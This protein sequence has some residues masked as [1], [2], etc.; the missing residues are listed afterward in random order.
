MARDEPCSQPGSSGE[1]MSMEAG[2]IEPRYL[3]L[4]VLL[5]QALTCIGKDGLAFCLVSLCSDEDLAHVVEAW[6][7]L[8]T[9]C[10]RLIL[11]TVGE[12]GAR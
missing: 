1:G 7:G 9:S 10:K 11:D 6:P 5:Q 8:P 3:D 12:R 4:Q 2:G